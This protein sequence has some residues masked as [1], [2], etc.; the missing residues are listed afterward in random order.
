MLLYK[1]LPCILVCPI[2]SIPHAHHL[3]HSQPLENSTPKNGATAIENA[4]AKA[5]QYHFSKNP[6]GF[7]DD[8][9]LEVDSLGCEP[10]VQA[11]H[12]AEISAEWKRLG[13][14]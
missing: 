8:A 12:Q 1:C 3:R 6:W 13:I 4:L 11:R 2:P 10:G 5:G 9:G 14:R 7:G